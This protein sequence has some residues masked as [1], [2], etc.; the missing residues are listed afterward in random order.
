MPAVQTQKQKVNGKKDRLP[1]VIEQLE[2]SLED[3][4]RGRVKRVL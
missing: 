3:L 2:Q 4:R 1:D